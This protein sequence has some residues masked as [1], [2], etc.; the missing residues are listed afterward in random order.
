[1]LG[2][3]ARHTHQT[4]SV[5]IEASS[6][7]VAQALAA[8]GRGIAVVTDDPRFD[9]ARTTI[10]AGADL[11]NLH[12]FAAWDPVHPAHSTLAAIAQRLADHIDDHYGSSS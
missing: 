1:V 4:V 2:A 7:A 10:T 3:A 12:L 5:D 9:L 6:G 8:A 11:L